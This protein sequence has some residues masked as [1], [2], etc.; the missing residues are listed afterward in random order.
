MDV[1]VAKKLLRER[2]WHDLPENRV[3]TFPLPVFGRVP[4]FAGSDEAA[5]R[6]KQLD[7]RKNTKVVFANPDAAQRNVRENALKEQGYGYGF[8]ETETRLHSCQPRSC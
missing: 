8:A 5:D 7:E 2:I 4:N 3:A 1:E 6:V